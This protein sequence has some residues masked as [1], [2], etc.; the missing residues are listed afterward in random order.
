MQGR[1]APNERRCRRS[2]PVMSR[3]VIG[4]ECRKAQQSDYQS[5]TSHGAPRFG[6]IRVRSYHCTMRREQVAFGGRGK[7]ILAF[8]ADV[9]PYQPCGCTIEE[10]TKALH[11][12]SLAQVEPLCALEKEG[13]FRKGEPRGVAFATARLAA[14]AQAVRDIIVQAWEES[15]NTP[16]GYLMVNVQDIESGKV[17]A[18]QEVFG[19]D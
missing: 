4:R 13:G 19:A 14:G 18:T 3:R 15:A 7:R 8:S 10:W 17:R 16:I 2:G 12:A 11:L 9:G 5:Q 6:R 1:F